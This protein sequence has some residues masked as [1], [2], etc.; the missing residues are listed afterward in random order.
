MVKLIVSNLRERPTRTVVSVLAISLGIAL[1]LVC[2]GLA[3]GQLADH[4]NR[5]KNVG[6]D[7]LLQPP[8]SSHIITFTGASLDA[9]LIRKVQEIKG[10]ASAAPVLVKLDGGLS[11][12]YGVERDYSKFNPNLKFWDG[13]MF[14]G[15]DEA[16][17]D[18]IFAAKH[19][20]VV[21]DVHT[22]LEQEFKIS[23]IFHSGSG[24]RVL[25]PLEEVQYL[26]GTEDKCTLIFVRSEDGE[27]QQTEERLKDG[28]QGYKITRSSE[29]LDIWLSNTPGFQQ[30]VT[31]IA[32]IAIIISFLI[33]L[34]SMYSTITERTREIGILKSLGASKGFIVGMVLKE[35]LMICVLGVVVGFALSALGIQLVSMAFPTLPVDTPLFWRFTAPIV[36][37]IGG[38]LGALYPAM[39]AAR[40]DPVRALGY[41]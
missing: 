16:V 35:S 27:L 11:Q 37:V 18:D 21:G 2:V 3:H 6:G 26:N 14:E 41:E 34:L 10:V 4:S 40:L 29:L 19:E 12:L 31:A 15:R 36:A 1:V 39:K 9:R 24:A 20:L 28:F 5:I 7:F 23:G 25:L 13:R 17:V 30:F 8:N 33:V 38:C 22:F 32:S